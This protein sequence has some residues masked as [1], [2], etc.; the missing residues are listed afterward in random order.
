[1][2]SPDAPVPMPIKETT[3]VREQELM[4]QIRVAAEFLSTLDS[5]VEKV[6]INPDTGVISYE[7]T[8]YRT[9]DSAIAAYAQE[10][11]E[12]MAEY[13]EHHGAFLL[14][15]KDNP[16]VLD[17]KIVAGAVVVTYDSSKGTVKIP[18]GDEMYVS[19]PEETERGSYNNANE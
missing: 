13:E 7:P 16:Q 8:I 17:A 11:Q 9:T 18:L 6:E 15:L 19:T 3:S 12:I 4:Q 2:D 10:H 5:I 1:M 14:E